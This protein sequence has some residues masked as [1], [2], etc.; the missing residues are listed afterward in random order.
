MTQDLETIS[1]RDFPDVSPFRNRSVLLL[2][3]IKGH[4]EHLRRGPV[5]QSL[6]RSLVVVKQE[7]G[8]QFHPG[9]T[10]ATVMR[11]LLLHLNA[12]ARRG[13]P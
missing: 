11:K 2:P 3:K 9:F 1:K 6:M 5:G 12:M 13:T 7:V 4:V 10:G 8:A